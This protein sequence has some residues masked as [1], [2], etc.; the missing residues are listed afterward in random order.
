MLDDARLFRRQDIRPQHQRGCLH[1]REQV[2]V[3]NSRTLPLV[4]LLFLLASS[5]AAAAPEASPA[6]AWPLARGTPGGTGVAG[7]ALAEKLTLA[8]TFTPENKG[9]DKQ[10]FQAGAAIAGGAV[11]V[12]STAGMLY[13]VDLATGRKNWEYDSKSDFKTTPAVRDGR[14]Y[15]G[16]QDGVFHCVEAATGKRLWKFACEDKID[17]PAAF[18]RDRVLFGSE[19]SNVYCLDAAG[20]VV[21]KFDHGG[22]GPLPGDRIGQSRLLCRL[23]RQSLCGG[24]GQGDY[25]RQNTDRRPHRLRRGLCE[26]PRLRGQRGQPIPGDRSGEERRRLALSGPGASDAVSLVGRGDGRR[27][28]CRLARQEAARLRSAD[29]PAALGVR[30][31]R[32]GRQLARGGR[33][34]GSSSVRRTGGF[35]ALDRRSGKE[36]WRYDAGGKIYASPAV[37]AGRLVIGSDV[38]KLYCF[39]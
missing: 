2:M 38:G 26:G 29:W 35:T 37:A 12:G 31:A 18:Y 5:A 19:D 20:N 25:A 36:V 7:S 10:G 17:S 28:L 6:D 8:W 9:S 23:Q 11:Y 30:D 4:V 24:P 34:R 14:V 22:P 1:R 13:S 3:Y 21:W 33:L 32:H 27:R 16:D 15:I 39:K